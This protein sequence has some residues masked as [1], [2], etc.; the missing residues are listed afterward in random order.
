M[1]QAV[2]A[3]GAEGDVQ[4]PA[5]GLNR[6][7]TTRWRIALAWVLTRALTVSIFLPHFPGKISV[8]DLHYYAQQLGHL[9]HG[10]T[11]ATTMP[12]YPLPMIAITMPQFLLGGTNPHA[13]AVLYVGSLLALDGGLLLALVRRSSY[14]GHPAITFWVWCLPAIGSLTYLRFDLIPSILVGL[15]LLCATHGRGAR[16]GAFTAFGAVLKLWP[17]ALVPVFLLRRGERKGVV[18]GFVATLVGIVLVCWAIGGWTRLIS[19]VKW[20]DGR[21]LQVESVPAAPLMFLRSL[22]HRTWYA[23]PTRW[24]ATEIFGPGVRTVISLTTVLMLAGA[25]Y[26]LWLWVRAY[27]HGRNDPVFV[28]WLL[29]TAILIVIIT[30][31]TFSPQYLLW[32]AGPVLAML[33]N[34]PDDPATRRVAI[35]VIAAGLVTQ[36]EFPDWY[37]PLTHTTPLT[38]AA[39][40]ALLVRDGIILWLTWV[41]ARQTHQHLTSTR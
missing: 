31:K 39:T 38:F 11:L 13:F 7:L 6:L 26:L 19:P 3:T 16:A 5:R 10:G 34:N 24:Q 1:T 14:A 37:Y 27:R 20:Q 8:N 22:N 41:A 18:F 30:N 9:T 33:W 29:L 35:G 23:M 17:G 2:S 15:A 32:L 25:L 28:G 40:T 12:E 4:L 21:G 36:L